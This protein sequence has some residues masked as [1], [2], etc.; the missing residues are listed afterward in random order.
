[1]SGA[2]S[3]CGGDACRPQR[4]NLLGAGLRAARLDE[5]TSAIHLGGAF[6]VGAS[7]V[8]PICWARICGLAKLDG[9]SLSDANLYDAEGSRRLT[10]SGDASVV[11]YVP[12]A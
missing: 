9:A 12:R 1:M 5:P 11:N 4:S 3:R 2:S 6:L 7:R 10:R 8:A